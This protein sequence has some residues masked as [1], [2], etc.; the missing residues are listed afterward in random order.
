MTL[1]GTADTEPESTDICGYEDSSWHVTFK[2]LDSLGEYGGPT[3][4]AGTYRY[5]YFI[6][7][8]RIKYTGTGTEDSDLEFN[9]QA[10][11]TDDKNFVIYYSTDGNTVTNE[12]DKTEFAVTKI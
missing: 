6:K 9:G 12:Y 4:A 7:E 5:V 2:N 10:T 8:T 11:R 3:P 1:D